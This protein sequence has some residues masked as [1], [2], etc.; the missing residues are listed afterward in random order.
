MKKVKYRIIFFIFFTSLTFCCN[1]FAMGP[2]FHKE[3]SVSLDWTF[4]GKSIPEDV[5]K[6]VL[7]EFFDSETLKKVELLNRAAKQ[8]IDCFRIKTSFIDGIVK[9]SAFS[10]QV[11]FKK[12]NEL[13]KEIKR[14][15]DKE[16]YQI[17]PV[18]CYD[19]NEAS[20]T[21][22]FFKS[23]NFEEAFSEFLHKKI[24][25]F[26]FS[27]N[28]CKE[29]LGNNLRLFLLSTLISVFLCLESSWPKEFIEYVLM[30]FLGSAF[31]ILIE[32]TLDPK[33]EIFF[34]KAIKR[35]NDKFKKEKD[36][37][38]NIFVQEESCSFELP[39]LNKY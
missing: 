20:D 6:Y 36:E 13:A 21:I 26:N 35:E 16:K 28:F 32:T 7:F 11:D 4:C 15:F 34:K 3:V 2:V 37:I 22:T 10:Y 31:L 9:K 5:I 18:V 8:A 39:V 23:K 38:D 19:E 25:E 1:S 29:H 17:C 27:A 33:I 12:I 24:K 30:G 14:R